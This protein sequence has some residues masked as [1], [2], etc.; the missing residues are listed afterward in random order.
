MVVKQ[1]PCRYCSSAFYDAR[2]KQHIS[3]FS[4]PCRSCEHI[5]S[6]EEY[7]KSKRKYEAGSVITSLEE[8]LEQTWVIWH[9]YTK[10]VE[11]FRSMPIRVVENFIKNG[12]IRR[13]IQKNIEGGK[14]IDREDGAEVRDSN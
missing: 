12:S 6:H 1:N 11:M 9:G 14:N 10:H 4:E 8:L 7:L 5:K 2:R 13:A 3:S